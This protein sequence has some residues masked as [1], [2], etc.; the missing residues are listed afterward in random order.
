M[1]L[2]KNDLRKVTDDYAP[3]L[4]RQKVATFFEDHPDMVQ[5]IN[6]L[7]STKVCVLAAMLDEKSI[8][9]SGYTIPADYGVKRASAVAHALDKIHSFPISNR[10]V[11]TE[12]E[13]GKMTKQSLFYI[14]HE[15]I[16]KLKQDPQSVFKERHE[17]ACRTRESQAQKEMKRLVK[18]YGQ[19]GVLELLKNAA[20]DEAGWDTTA[21]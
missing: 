21:S 8:T 5:S 4:A 6:E 17:N 9:T 16:E 10:L 18:E 14:S 19:D 11:E 2:M 1:T 12:S 20:N 15:D 13:V 7:S 3:E